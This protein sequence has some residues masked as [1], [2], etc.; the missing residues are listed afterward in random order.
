MHAVETITFRLVADADVAAFLQAD[1]RVQNEFVPFQ[2]G[3]LRRTTARS[4]DGEWI[5]VL[6]WGS[7]ADADTATARAAADPAVL[8]FRRF[9][10]AASQTAAAYETLD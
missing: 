10:D 9:I 8:A 6:L 7:L 2:P 4:A 1:E 5:V 3:F